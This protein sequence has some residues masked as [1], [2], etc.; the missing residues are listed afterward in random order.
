MD[1]IDWIACLTSAACVVDFR[2]ANPKK[3]GVEEELGVIEGG[4]AIE[5]VLDLRSHATK[6]EEQAPKGAA[7]VKQ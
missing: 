3:Q 7:R 4:G 5:P 2:E 6:R 1:S